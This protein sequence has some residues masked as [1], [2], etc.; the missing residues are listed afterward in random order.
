MGPVMPLHFID[1][2]FVKGTSTEMIDVH[3]PATE[4]VIDSVP[5][6][7]EADALA[8]VG[9][10]KRAYGEWRRTSANVRATMMHDAAAK[11][12]Q[13]KDKIVELLTLEEGKPVPENEEEFEWLCNT[14]DYYAELGRHERGRVLPSGEASQLNLV[15]KEP[16]GVAACIIPWNY[17]LL[18]LAW[19]MAPALAAGNTV[20]IKPSELTP[21]TTM[22][23][24][25]KCWD[26]FPPGV[27]N[28]VNGFGPEVAEPLVLHKDVPVIAFT[29]SLQIGQRIATLAGPKM[30]KLHLE[31]GGKDAFV[32]SED[33]EPEMTARAL[34]YAALTNAGQ[35]CTSTERVYLPKSRAKE[36]TEALVEHVRKL[37]LGPGIEH[38]T[39]IG[40]MIGDRYRQKV[41]NHIS[42]AVSKGAKVLVG[43]KRPDQLTKG[44]Y[45]EPTVLT[46]VN[47]S[48]QI[49]REETF[50]P[51]I[52]L[53]EYSSFDEA[54]ELTNDSDFGL[55]ACLVTSDPLKAK[56]FMEEVKAG[57]V[58]INDPLT[59]NYAGPFGGMK[60]SGGAR[61]LGQEG[62]DEFRETKHVHWDFAASVKP[63]WYP[64]GGSN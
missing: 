58:W 36:F 18:L 47:H 23:L 61:E 6:G 19:K 8:A 33:A 11:M 21:L 56:L 24:A 52:P 5:R 26:H 48:M 20:V 64:Y 28:V 38:S 62:L 13:H 51:A 17:P 22:L 2:K 55:G 45:L 7:T 12:R 29:G 49:M 40:P 3:N 4:G 37:K 16:Y 10:A 30:K 31:L 39:D 35:V 32:V 43:G 25:E 60:F 9:A 34:A 57:T 53:M 46:N 50:G 1:G 44:F 54:I 14:F 63:W 27:I 42:E 15:I 41:E 59:D